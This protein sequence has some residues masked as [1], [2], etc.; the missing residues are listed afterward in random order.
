M[1]KIVGS[2][3][4]TQDT[5]W[6][7]IKES[8]YYCHYYYYS[9]KYFLTITVELIASWPEFLKKTPFLSEEDDMLPRRWLLKP[10]KNCLSIRQTEVRMY[11]LS[12]YAIG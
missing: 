8:G 5:T 12:F 1:H 9:V 10:R 11:S 3:E 6:P 2:F 4:S 7:S